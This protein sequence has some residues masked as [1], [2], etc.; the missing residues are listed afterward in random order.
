MAWKD[1]AGWFVCNSHSV[2]FVIYRR[3]TPSL[4]S[5]AT[6][7]FSTVHLLVHN[8]ESENAW[9]QKNRGGKGE[10]VGERQPA[11]CKENSIKGS[12][13]RGTAEGNWTTGET[14]IVR[15]KKCCTSLLIFEKGIC[16]RFGVMC[17]QNVHILLEMS[18]WRNINNYLWFIIYIVW[19]SNFYATKLY[20]HQLKQKTIFYAW[21]N[22]RIFICLFALKAF[23]SRYLHCIR[24]PL[25]FCKSLDRWNFISQILR[26]KA[27]LK[28]WN[29]CIRT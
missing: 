3:S 23:S 18:S 28:G 16:I 15:N 20:L 1:C 26:Y 5:T 25:H 9:Q 27:N 11:D 14:I 19:N 24:K 17:I 29:E 12:G 21:V 8:T 10:N 22:K 6:S 7:Q 4:G 2:R 13:K